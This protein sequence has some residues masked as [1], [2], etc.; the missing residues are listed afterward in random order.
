MFKPESGP[1]LF[2]VGAVLLAAAWAMYYADRHAVFLDQLALALSIAGQFAVAGSVL[3]DHFSG[4]G[5]CVHRA[6]RAATRTAR[7]A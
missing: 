1:M 3:K 5:V 6:G 2:G 7:H 4:L